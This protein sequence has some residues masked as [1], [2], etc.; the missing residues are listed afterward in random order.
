[1]CNKFNKPKRLNIKN[2]PLLSLRGPNVLFLSQVW[3]YGDGSTHIKKE[4][5]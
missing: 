2:V 3:P 4:V 1:M 5:E